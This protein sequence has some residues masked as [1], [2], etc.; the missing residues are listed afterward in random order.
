MFLS[1][2][3]IMIEPLNLL[4]LFTLVI[5]AIIMIAE[6]MS[7]KT[8]IKEAIGM[9]MVLFVL[10]NLIFF[11]NIYLDIGLATVWGNF[12]IELYG[13]LFQNFNVFET[14][15]I[16]GFIPLL[17]G[18]TGMIL[19][20]RRNTAINIVSAIILSSFTLLL[21]KLIAFEYGLIILAVVFCITSAI[22]INWFIDYLNLTKI[23]KYTS[24]IVWGLILISLVSLIVPSISNAEV[25]INEGV[26]QGEVDVLTWASIY[27]EEDSVILGNVYEGNFRN[28]KIHG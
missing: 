16:I 21:L 24:Y 11:K 22:S 27:A 4:M 26:S 7:L 28:G 18:V 9:H 25:V 19:A 3:Y 6:S 13:S 17:L 15:S 14:V 5:F 23:S 1:F 8:E 12:P 2:V 20:P 10:V